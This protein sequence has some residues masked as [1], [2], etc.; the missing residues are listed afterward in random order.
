MPIHAGFSTVPSVVL[1]TGCS[2]GCN[3]YNILVNNT[4]S[5]NSSN[6][7]G[8]LRLEIGSQSEVSINGNESSYC[9]RGRSSIGGSS[10]SSG[11]S[12]GSFPDS[13]VHVSVPQS[14]VNNHHHYHVDVRQEQ[15]AVKEPLPPPPYNKS[16]LNN[17]IVSNYNST[18]YR[19]N[20]VCSHL[21]QFN[22]L[23]SPNHSCSTSNTSRNFIHGSDFYIQNNNQPVSHDC[24]I[25][26]HMSYKLPLDNLF[27]LPQGPPPPIPQRPASRFTCSSPGNHPPS[28]PKKPISTY[29]I[30]DL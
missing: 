2:S 21:L 3:G 14:L 7:N 25:A 16:T 26:S 22:D 27:S 10:H 19:S 28:L 12:Q 24:H 5:G 1:K 15:R 29:A 13:T 8:G 17:I 9:A 6:H 20:G 30:T 11:G 4:R 18:A 23:T